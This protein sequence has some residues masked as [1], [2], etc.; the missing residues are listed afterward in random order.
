MRIPIQQAME[1]LNLPEYIIFDKETYV[2]WKSKARFIDVI[3]GEWWTLPKYVAEGRRHPKRAV[4]FMVH[5][6]KI[7]LEVAK[8]RLKDKSAWL[9]D[10]TYKSWS[11]KALFIHPI[12]GEWWTLPSSIVNGHGHPNDLS[13]RTIATKLKKY[14]KIPGQSYLKCKNF[15][16]LVGQTYGSLTVIKIANEKP[17]RWEC[18]CSC[19]NIVIV[20]T[21]P[22]KNGHT[23]SC[24]CLVKKTKSAKSIDS[25]SQ[26]IGSIYNSWTVIGV[27]TNETFKVQCQC[28]CGTI[29][30]VS[31]HSLLKGISK[32]CGCITP[33]YKTEED[34]RAVLERITGYSWPKNRILRNPETNALLEFDGYCKE[35]KMAFEY[36]G[37]QHYKDQSFGK[38]SFSLEKRQ[39]MD[40]L[41]DNLS[42]QAGIKLLRIPF[43][44]KGNLEEFISKVLEEKE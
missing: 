22:L 24:G 43:W 27:D 7:S 8:I 41:K 21:A 4:H 6:N 14:G 33:I 3:F 5:H 18:K 20:K 42:K 10:S 44:E 17:I 26:L 30:S 35:L 1:R 39:Q 13:K 36:D 9:V 31:K 25:R 15:V 2:G 16:D 40:L 34:C 11:K 28:D 12:H 23:R 19:G 29:R 32:C 38:N 37:E